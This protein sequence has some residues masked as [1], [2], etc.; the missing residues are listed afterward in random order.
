MTFSC[1]TELNDIPGALV[2]LLLVLAGCVNLHEPSS[3]SQCAALDQGN[4]PAGVAGKPGL[5][6]AVVN[7]GGHPGA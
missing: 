1:S 4:G 6:E 7:V 2:V 5:G 3:T